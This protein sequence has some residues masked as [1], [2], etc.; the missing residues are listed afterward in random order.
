MRQ[1][2]DTEKYNPKETKVKYI[3]NGKEYS[4][5]DINKR[6]AGI[7]GLKVFKG[8]VSKRK[9]DCWVRITPYHNYNPCYNWSDAGPIID[10]VY[11]KLNSFG[12]S[13]SMTQ[14]EIGIQQHNCTKLVAACICLIEINGG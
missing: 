9:G 10:K 5:L 12:K 14:W 11:S 1:H 6:C 3:I 13:S 8:C 7:M 2:Y 4:E